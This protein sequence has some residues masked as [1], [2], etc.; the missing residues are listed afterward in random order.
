ME[1]NDSFTP[2]PWMFDDLRS[3][4]GP[5]VISAWHFQYGSLTHAEV[6]AGC[7]EANELG[8]MLANARL[9]AAAPKLLAALDAFMTAH[10]YLDT[11]DRML[12]GMQMGCAYEMAQNAI[13][14]ATSANLKEPQS[15]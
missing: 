6:R 4:G 11:G 13:A 1:R 3:E 14:L 5:I 7:N 8:D 2:G 10:D 9:I 12:A 15:P